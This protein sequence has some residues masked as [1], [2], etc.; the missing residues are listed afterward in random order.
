MRVYHI[1]RYRTGWRIVCPNGGVLSRL[2]FFP[3]G[4]PSISPITYRFFC[5]VKRDFRRCLR[6]EFGP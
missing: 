4:W 2:D 1:E 3:N 5:S 6:G